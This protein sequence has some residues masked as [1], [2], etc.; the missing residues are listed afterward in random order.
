MVEMYGSPYDKGLLE[1]SFADL[2]NRLRS[3]DEMEATAA[4]LLVMVSTSKG[5]AVPVP[6]LI[7]ALIDLLS[8]S[9]ALRQA[10][11]WALVSLSGGVFGLMERKPLWKPMDDDVQVLINT[12][13]KT[14]LTEK[15]TIG[16]LIAILG[17]SSDPS[18]AAAI[19]QWIEDDYKEVRRRAV[20]ALGRLG[21]KVAMAPLVQR[22]DDKD[23]DIRQAAG[24]AL[25]RLGDR[26]AVTPFVQ[27][28]EYENEDVRRAAVE[29]LGRLGDKAAVAPLVQDRKSVV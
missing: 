27:L 10:A 4:A 11:A 17:T 28:L 25:G 29:A 2:P 5:K 6:G 9:P 19:I 12:M 20:R 16:Y 1:T 22:L 21:D 24:E 26:A 15:E 3:L 14:P 13:K 8:G 23:D 18:A 7:P